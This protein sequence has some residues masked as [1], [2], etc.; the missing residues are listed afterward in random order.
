MAAN[1]TPVTP[2][3]MR[4]LAVK[5]MD[6]FQE[7]GYWDEMSI[8]VDGE[9]WS[10]DSPGG[11]AAEKCMT[12]NGTAYYARKN[13]NVAAQ[14]EYCNPETVS[15]YFEGPLYETINYDDYDFLSKLDKMFLDQYGL[16]FEQGYAWSI[17]AYES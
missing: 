11:K 6:Y 9:C 5:L 2:K 16:Y 8:Y 14:L 3:A 10:S 17:A 1:K 13:V 4:K 12:P 15:I 7:N